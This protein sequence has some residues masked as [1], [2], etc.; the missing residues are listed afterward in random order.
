MEDLTTWQ[1]IVVIFLAGIIF[2]G[3]CRIIFGIGSYLEHKANFYKAKVRLLKAENTG[4]FNKRY[5]RKKL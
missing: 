5:D 3:I 2:I 1:M 4:V